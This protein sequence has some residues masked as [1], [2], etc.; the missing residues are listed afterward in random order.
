MSIEEIK[1]K[2]TE[3]GTGYQNVWVY[4]IKLPPEEVDKILDQL[5]FP[6]NIGEDWNGCDLDWSGTITLNGMEIDVWGSGYGGS[7]VFQKN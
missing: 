3:M 2:L 7:M 6:H 4:P 5:G 1:Q